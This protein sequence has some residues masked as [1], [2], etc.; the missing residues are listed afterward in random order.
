MDIT[1]PSPSPSSKLTPASSSS[2]AKSG[3]P[4]KP[5]RG[6]YREYH[7]GLLASIAG[8]NLAPDFTLSMP[9]CVG[10]TCVC[11]K[12][13]DEIARGTFWLHSQC[14]RFVATKIMLAKVEYARLVAEGQIEAPK[15]R[16]IKAAP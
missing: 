15:P 8:V 5:P 16:T 2:A 12:R 9:R 7:A 10:D 4:Y 3:S 14:V 6:A 11:G 13:G 1:P